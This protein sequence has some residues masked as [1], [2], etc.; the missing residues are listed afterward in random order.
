MRRCARG[1]PRNA[2]RG[3]IAGQAACESGRLPTPHGTLPPFFVGF[4]RCLL[5]YAGTANVRTDRI[6]VS[7]PYPFLTGRAR[8]R[9]VERISS[10]RMPA[11][12]PRDRAAGSAQPPD[13]RR[14]D[15]SGT[16]LLRST[17][18]PRGTW[19]RSIFSGDSSL[20]RRLDRDAARTW[21]LSGPRRSTV[22]PCVSDAF[23]CRRADGETH[24]RTGARGRSPRGASPERRAEG[25][26]P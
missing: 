16:A 14:I 5:T 1:A 25:K 20:V 17:F 3:Y 13:V 12:S 2:P 8:C 15:F 24:L 4:S 23:A 22:S 21:A 19:K 9:Q 7:R 18:Q 26:V 10:M 11:S 6:R